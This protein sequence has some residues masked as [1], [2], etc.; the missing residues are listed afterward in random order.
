MGLICIL[1]AGDTRPSFRSCQLTLNSSGNSDSLVAQIFSSQVQLGISQYCTEI[2]G[3]TA[4]AA[5]VLPSTI[6]M[7]PTSP[8]VE[9]GQALSRQT[10]AQS[11]QALSVCPARP[12]GSTP[13]R[14]TRQTSA[15]SPTTR[16][17]AGKGGR[18]SCAS[19]SRARARFMSYAPPTEDI[20]LG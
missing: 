9:T 4:V 15:A 20:M 7:L 11:L 14:P 3:L 12:R 2:F 16:G 19:T 18:F 17:R 8:S 13:S 1:A 6:W 5:P 10:C